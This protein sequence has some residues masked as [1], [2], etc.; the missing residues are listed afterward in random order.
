MTDPSALLRRDLD[1]VDWVEAIGVEPDI[2]VIEG[3][4][5]LDAPSVGFSAVGGA[6]RRITTV[7][8]HAGVRHGYDPYGGALPHG[9]RFTLA[10]AEVHEL[11]GPPS[12]S[13]GGR[14][15]PVLGRANAWDRWQ[16][17]GYALH[18]E[19]DATA[20]SVVLVS[21]MTEPP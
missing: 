4:V 13:G 8:L 1:A 9:L 17:E 14:D 10:R 6:D 11:L 16:V 3:A 21:L 5:Y 20:T 12:R 19:Y 2:E 15:V 18:C 7:Q